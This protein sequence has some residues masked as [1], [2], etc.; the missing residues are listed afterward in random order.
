[1]Q[2]PANP[3]KAALRDGRRQIGLWLGLASPYSAELLAGAG[4]DW[5]LID[6]EHAPNELNDVLRQLQA[7]APYPSHPV[8]RAVSNDPVRIK[9][10][11]DIGAQTLMLPMV[12][13]A[14]EAARAVAATRYP[15]RGVRGVGSALARASRWNR[16][17]D[18]LTRAD[19]EIC[20][21]AQVETRQALAALDAI[22]ATDGVDGVFIGPADLA[23]DMGHPGRPDHPDVRA[24]MDDAILRIRAQGK[25]AGILMANEA[26]ARRLLELGA[27]FVAVGVDTTLL[28][29]R[30]E[31]LAAAFRHDAPG[32]PPPPS[33]Y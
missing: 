31:A 18:Y 26:E 6:G 17:P 30:A 3:F 9:Q 22:A 10:L 28:A 1:M 5:L 23:A 21:L 4:F 8:V 11:L 24:A 2:L 32:Q 15:P 12:Q 27:N 20:V 29:R 25:A 14:D 7:I 13:N 19:S 16:V 33:A